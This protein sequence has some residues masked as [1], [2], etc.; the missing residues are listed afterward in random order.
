MTAVEEAEARLRDV[1]VPAVVV[2]RG[3]AAKGH[4]KHELFRV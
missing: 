3:V 2:K 4:P 1:G